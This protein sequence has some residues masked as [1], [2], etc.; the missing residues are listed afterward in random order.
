[1]S[2]LRVRAQNKLLSTIGAAKPSKN[3][4]FDM[5]YAGFEK[6]H[7]GI[8]ELDAAFRGFIIS[9]RG[10]HVSA[11]ALVQV[12]DNA[13]GGAATNESGGSSPS[14]EMKQFAG[15]IK[16]SFVKLDG[17]LLNETVARYEK[18]V[19]TP[20]LGWL[21]RANAVKQQVASF[22]EEKT[23]F[24]HY[25]RKVMA[26]REARDKRAAAG[27][28]EK[29]KDV[30][31]L[32][33]NEQKYAAITNTYAKISDQTIVNLRD[34]VNARD[35]TLTP[36]LHRFL[37]FRKHYATQV[38]EESQKL[39]CT[40]KS[41]GSFADTVL[42]KLESLVTSSH[43][44]G[45]QRIATAPAPKELKEDETDVPV[46]SFSFESFVGEAPP[47]IHNEAAG[48]TATEDGNAAFNAYQPPPPPPLVPALASPS[49]PD[50]FFT[51]EFASP[52][53]VSISPL[54]SPTL[55]AAD[56]FQTTP[57]PPPRTS[58]M[59][60]VNSTTASAP[61]SASWDDMAYPSK[62]PAP[63]PPPFA[64]NFNT[65]PATASSFSASPS[66][67]GAFDDVNG[68]PSTAAPP[69]SGSTDNPFAFQANFTDL[70]QN[71]LGTAP[72]Q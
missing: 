18:R 65:M 47:T 63:S 22:H 32:V 34:F 44:P 60:M 23:L 17:H 70:H 55:F 9:L 54:A 41:G 46:Q 57:L 4:Q 20:T 48:H 8:V 26:L 58:S 31:K 64:S 16:A 38:Y 13:A 52:R 29:P 66:S 21:T 36:I 43:P 7:A 49:S 3:V 27:K 15:A 69:N 56:Q 39:P 37:E 6:T 62:P 45:A 30:E 71:A 61:F 68:P 72:H 19:L 28:S 59:L 10:F 2:S 24:D 42:S 1:M 5:A 50:G 51:D 14:Y 11:Q 40:E 35:E 12:I 67:W 25:T 33:R 53:S